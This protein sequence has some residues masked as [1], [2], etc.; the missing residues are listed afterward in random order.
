M[1]TVI[2]PFLDHG[3]AGKNANPD[4]GPADGTQDFTPAAAADTKH[5]RRIGKGQRRLGKSGG[6]HQHSR[7]RRRILHVLLYRVANTSLAICAA[8]MAA[9]Q[10]A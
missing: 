10:P 6:G 9:G 2:G 4:L 7:H 1:S 5:R 3:A 8:V